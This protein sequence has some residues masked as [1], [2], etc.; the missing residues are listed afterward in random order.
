MRLASRSARAVEAREL[1]ALFRLP[2]SSCLAPSGASRRS[3]SSSHAA[4]TR[5]RPRASRSQRAG[6]HADGRRGDADL[7]DGDAW[8]VPAHRR[9]DRAE[10]RR[11]GHRL[12]Y[13][14]VN[15][16]TTSRR[17]VGPRHRRTRGSPD[18]ATRCGA[19]T[20]TTPASSS[21]SRR[22]ARSR[23]VAASSP[24]APRRRRSPSFP[25]RRGGSAG[26][27]AINNVGQIVG[28]S[29]AP[30]FATHAV[31][32]SA[33]ASSRISARSAAP[34]ARRSTSTTPARSSARAR[35]PATRRRTSSSGRPAAGCRT[36][37]RRSTP[38]SRASSRSTTRARSSARTRTGGAVAR[39]PL[40]ARL[41]AARPRHARRH[42][43]RPHGAQ[44]QRRRRREQ[45]PRRRLDARVPLDGR[46][47]MEDITA[48]SGVPEVGAS[49]TICRP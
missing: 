49:T 4:A 12:G 18:A 23:A 10:Q 34:T 20:S 3:R 6:S 29:A 40:Y 43:E 8:R 11:P 35:S 39:L 15:Q 24:P 14:L 25:A 17:S 36:S 27:V 41:R 31:L 28:S 2:S 37:T 16:P 45:H 7:P 9:R 32:W 22:P 26:A 48:L 44:Q 21:A 1:P 42:D 38:R 33:R 46:R 13:V 47:G 30:G 19:T 5:S